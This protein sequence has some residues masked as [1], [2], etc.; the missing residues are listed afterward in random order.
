MPYKAI[1]NQYRSWRGNVSRKGYK[2]Y[3]QVSRMDK[4]YNE[5]YIE[6]FIEGSYA[7]C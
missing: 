1:D 3:R 7:R 6:P 2:N 5:L 4:L